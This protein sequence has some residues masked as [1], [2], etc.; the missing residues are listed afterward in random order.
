[1]KKLLLL[2]M[3]VSGLVQAQYGGFDIVGED[4]YRIGELGSFKQV[5]TFLSDFATPLS[6]TREISGGEAEFE[7]VNGGWTHIRWD[8]DI[9]SIGCIGRHYIY[10][11]NDGRYRIWAD[12]HGTEVRAVT[13]SIYNTAEEAKT[14]MFEELDLYAFNVGYCN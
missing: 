3:L 12:P 11:T 10:R 9:T 5:G 13:T 4:I 14:E 8:S 6:E 1:M 7:R 2:F